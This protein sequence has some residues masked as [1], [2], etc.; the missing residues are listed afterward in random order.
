MLQ[1]PAGG[2]L[3]LGQPHSTTCEGAQG[4]GCWLLAATS[5]EQQEK[6]LEPGRKVS[7]SYSVPFE[8]SWYCATWRNVCTKQD[9]KHESD[10]ERQEIDKWPK[11]NSYYLFC[12]S[13]YH[14]QQCFLL[15]RWN[16]YHGII[17]YCKEGK[18][19]L[20]WKLLLKST[21]DATVTWGC[22]NLNTLSP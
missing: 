8:S 7:S 14:S 1:K 18:G 15:P 22:V 11:H 17:L 4:Q 6:A 2:C 21:N 5:W 3:A 20:L 12:K 19:S 16:S 10:D 13:K 9:K